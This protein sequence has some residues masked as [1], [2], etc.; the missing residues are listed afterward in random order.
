MSFRKT[1]LRHRNGAL[2]DLPLLIPSFSSKGFGFF[3]EKKGKRRITLSETTRA[4]ES[5]GPYLQ[6]TFLLSAYDLHHGHFHRPE[7]FFE[8]SAL[9]FVDSGGYELNDEFDSSEPKLTPVRK[10][11]FTLDDYN[12]VLSS[13]Y[14]K[15]TK[16]PMVITNFDM[17]SQRQPFHKQIQMARLLFETYPQWSHN[18]LMKPDT[19]KGSVIDVDRLVPCIDEL[20]GF[21]V[22][23]VTEKEL[24][25]N[26]IDRLR[27]LAR[28]RLALSQR[29]IHSPIHVWGGLDPLLTPLYFF[30]GADIFDGVSWLR[31]VYHSGMAVNRECYS[32]LNNSLTMAHDH[33]IHLALNQNLT[34]LQ[35]LATSLRAFGSSAEPNFDV[36]GDSREMLAN[37]YHTL[38]ARVSELKEL[39]R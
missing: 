8:I 28:L 35:G 20:R 24:G 10:L 9:I 5:L 15:G 21:D 30:A 39:D 22:I 4:L 6:E 13:L 34:A 16:L 11:Q 31:Y 3:T 1:A 29:K 38:R 26:L 37:A 27:R 19:S 32:V 33:A 2:I 7:R 12:A 23:G 18:F 17:E 25:K 36:F 14:R